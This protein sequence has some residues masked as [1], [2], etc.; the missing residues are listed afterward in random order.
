MNVLK[1]LKKLFVFTPR[2]DVESWI[3]VQC[4]RCG[5]IIAA[6]INLRN[7]LSIVY[8]EEGGED[9]YI[10]RK[11]LIGSGLCFQQI[12]IE[13]TYN[14]NRTL[15][16]KSIKGGKFLSEEDTNKQRT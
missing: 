11:V 12:E 2:A 15:V 3:Y 6:R 9:H 7:D 13:L 16:E 10:C 1:R 14:S 4:D 5:E 8:E